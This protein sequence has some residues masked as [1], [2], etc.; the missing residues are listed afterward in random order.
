MDVKHQTWL[1]LL[2]AYSDAVLITAQKG[3]YPLIAQV[4]LLDVDLTLSR[5]FDKVE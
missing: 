5:E 2:I 3:D 1:L 4:K